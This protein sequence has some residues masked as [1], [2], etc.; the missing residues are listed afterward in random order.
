[1]SHVNENLTYRYSSKSSTD[2]VAEVN[3]VNADISR[4]A[5]V[6]CGH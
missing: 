4:R 5:A 2:V 1:M 6:R 3:K